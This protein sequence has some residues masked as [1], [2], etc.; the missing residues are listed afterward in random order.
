MAG[1]IGNREYNLR[2]VP[3]L[4][5]GQ[6][7]SGAADGDFVAISPEAP[8]YNHTAGSLGE[9]AVSRNNNQAGTVTIRVFQGARSVIRIIENAIR[10]AETAGLQDGTFIAIEVADLNTGENLIM[11][12]CWPADQPA[13]NFG[14]E[15]QVREYVFG[16]SE[17]VVSPR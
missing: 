13:R 1:V 3:V 5:N 8:S 10:L 15:Q 17:L 14:Q 9:V 6:L 4:F 11:A 7:L 2:R 16:Y 12:Q